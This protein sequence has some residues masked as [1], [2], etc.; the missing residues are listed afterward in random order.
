M[1]ILDVSS[2]KDLQLLIDYLKSE[3]QIEA[4]EVNNRE[5][6]EVN[7]LNAQKS[8][9]EREKNLYN[10]NALTT[11]YNFIYNAWRNQLYPSLKAIDSPLASKLNDRF[12]DGG[13]FLSMITKAAEKELLSGE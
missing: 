3:I 9:S 2:E 1:K 12:T 13:V 11:H 5:T 7:D 10:I 6:E 4:S 8:P